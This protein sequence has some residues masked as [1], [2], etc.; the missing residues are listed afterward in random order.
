M[1]KLI[2]IL[3]A[4]MILLT[5][6][7]LADDLSAM[8]D[9]ELK[10]LLL[11][12]YDELGRRG[13][14][15]DR[16]DMIDLLKGEAVMNRVMEFYTYWSADDL[17]GML[18]MCDA[19]WQA[20]QENARTALFAVLA[21]RTPLS[22]QVTEPG[23]EAEGTRRVTVIAQMDR[24][25]GKEPAY[26]RHVILMKEAADGE[27]YV[28]PRSL[29]AYET[30]EGF[31]QAEPTPEPTDWSG[32]ESLQTTLLSYVPNG[33][34]KYHLDENCPAV[35][36]KYLPMRDCFAYWE[37]NMDE[38]KDLKPCKVCGAPPRDYAPTDL[39]DFLLKVFDRSGIEKV[40]YLR[41]DYFVGGERR[42]YICSCPNEGEDFYRFPLGAAA[43]D[44]L[45][46]LRV[47][48]SYGVSDLSPE[49]AVLEVM[50][51]AAMEEHPLT[52]MD[53]VP[54]GGKTYR[55]DLEPDGADGWRL[56]PAEE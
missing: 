42:G 44:E 32:D 1:K 29:A 28:D 54:E 26:Y 45:K 8:T 11:E 4:M 47:E 56:V 40:S 37:L 23:D 2:G 30:A 34:E 10:A 35:N 43:Q 36:E 50:K 55:L 15:Y 39:A 46:D 9:E 17:D 41:A 18:E 3:L 27:W 53:F 22:V 6:A 7:A 48:F 38:Y 5:S 13:Y 31:I 52:T 51:G 33:G 19:D 12:V 20:E 21:N 16:A 49:D 24:H 25:N 14:G